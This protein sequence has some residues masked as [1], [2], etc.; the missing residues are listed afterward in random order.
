MN[1]KFLMSQLNH[2]MA[3]EGRYSEANW[4]ARQM[5]L[6]YD[7]IEALNT[8]YN[9]LL[10]GKWNGMMA[11]STSFTN[12]CQFYQKPEVKHFVGAGEKAVPLAPLRDTQPDACNVIDLTHPV[13]T[14]SVTIVK[15]L[16][17]DGIAVQLGDP[18]STPDTSHPTSI[19]Y[20][21]TAPQQDS[22]DIVLYTVPFW[23]LY[24]GKS[25]NVG[26]SIDNSPIQV[27]ENKFK[28]YDRRW[29]D[30]VM[31]NGAVC[32]LR[33][34]T[35]PSALTTQPLKPVTRHTL[36][37]HGIDPGQMVQRII[38]DWGGL[39]SSYIGPRLIK[40]D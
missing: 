2:E 7:S 27:F 10:D 36:T 15:G 40:E 35:P 17:Y 18:T 14:S 23:P 22:I 32:R 33:F 29:K 16:G 1:R 30:Q 26:I 4:A 8:R 38:V 5:E 13:N 11:L 34:A 20:E 3:A 21:F 6:A 12:T 37:L 19:T 31:R 25:N 39:K 9:N 24:E 28:E